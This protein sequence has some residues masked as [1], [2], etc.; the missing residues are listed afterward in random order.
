MNTE[1]AI[2]IID[3]LL[4]DHFL[5]KGKDNY[6]IDFVP[7][8]FQNDDFNDLAA[9]LEI[10]FKPD[11]VKKITFIAFTIMHYYESYV[12]LD[13]HDV[14]P[15]YPELI[16]KDLRHLGIEALAKLIN[17]IVIENWSSINILFK[18]DGKLSLLRIEDGLDSYFFNLSAGTLEVAKS[19]VTQQ[20]LYLKLIY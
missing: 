11:F 20:G 8:T 3:K 7:V 18:N 10:H 5:G 16:N 12:F 9:Y 13:N 2:N 4:E 1:K 14:E 15:L 19:L 17:K 6:L